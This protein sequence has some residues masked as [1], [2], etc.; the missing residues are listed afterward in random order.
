MATLKPI[1]IIYITMTACIGVIMILY[2]ISVGSSMQDATWCDENC[3]AGTYIT[4]L[5]LA[6]FVLLLIVLGFLIRSRS[7]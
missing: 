4:S 5:V 3:I 1:T 2:P 7:S 6:I